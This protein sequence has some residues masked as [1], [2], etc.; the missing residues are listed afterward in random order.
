[1]IVAVAGVT[2]SLLVI[3][4][5]RIAALLVAGVLAAIAPVVLRNAVV[6]HQFALVSSQGGLNFYIGNN[7][8]ATGQYVAVPGVRANIEGQSQDTR[9][10]AEQAAGH[11]LTDAQ[12]SAHFSGLATLDARPSGAPRRGSLRASSRWY[13]TRITNGSISAIPYYARDTGTLLLVLFVGPWLLVPLGLT[14]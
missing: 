2:L 9:R 14:G 3:R 4:R 6:S 1:M 5:F 11:P 8:S 12:V 13:S 7:E 10:V